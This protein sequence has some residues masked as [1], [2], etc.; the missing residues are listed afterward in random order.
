MMICVLLPGIL[1]A[2]VNRRLRYVEQYKDCAIA[3]MQ[4]AGI[5]ASITLAQ[6]ILES[7]CGDSYLATEANNHFGIK[8]HDWQGERVYHDDDK[9]GECFRKYSSAS[10]SFADHSLFLTSKQR[11]SSLFE[12]DKTDYKAWARGL[13]EAG[14]A[15]D[16][17]YADRLIAII[18]EMNLHEFDLQQSVTARSNELA[19]LGE[20]A[21]RVVEASEVAEKAALPETTPKVRIRSDASFVI[22]LYEPHTVQYN[23]GVRYVQTRRGDTMEGIALEFHLMVSELLSYNDMSSAGE[24]GRTHFI[25][26]RPKHNRAHSDCERHTVRRNDTPW[27]VAHKYGIKL[28]KLCKY[29]NI[30]ADEHLPIGHELYLRGAKQ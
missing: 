18:E 8:C 13:K 10:E 11:Y 26:I 25:Y 2:Q 14:Y 4:S 16:P 28:K 17:S 22:D 3:E 19:T 15:T 7:D 30:T 24:I 9:S 5:P 12:L 27:S 20:E 1:V 23:N 21:D 29:N 6:G